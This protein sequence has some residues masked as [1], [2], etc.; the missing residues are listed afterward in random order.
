MPVKGDKRRNRRPRI[1][2][3]PV[4]NPEIIGERDPRW[5]RPVRGAMAAKMDAR[6]KAEEEAGEGD[7]PFVDE[8]AGTT[9]EDAVV[10]RPPAET[11][12]VPTHAASAPTDAAPD[13][14]PVAPAPEPAPAPVAKPRRS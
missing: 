14:A 8:R 13:A 9:L 4:T 10:K 5:K 12:V 1:K 7:T 2:S 3:R 11:K 6:D